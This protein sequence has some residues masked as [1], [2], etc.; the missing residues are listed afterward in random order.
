[1]EGSLKEIVLKMLESL[2]YFT[3]REHVA[4]AAHVLKVCA[5]NYWCLC[6]VSKVTGYYWFE[7]ASRGMMQ[8]WL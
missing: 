4:P 6:L 7:W 1:M 2:L 3:L 8:H 5:E